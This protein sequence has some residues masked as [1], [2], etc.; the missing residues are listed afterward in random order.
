MEA[1]RSSEMTANYFNQHSRKLDSVTNST[2][3][4]TSSHKINL[5]CS[6]L[7]HP[8]LL[9][10][11]N[12]YSTTLMHNISWDSLMSCCGIRISA[13]KCNTLIQLAYKKKSSF[14]NK[15]RTKACFQ[16][17]WETIAIKLTVVEN[18]PSEVVACEEAW[19]D[20]DEA[21]LAWV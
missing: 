18:V 1:T 15:Y 14:K 3:V 12:I 8:L 2:T 11:M 10:K 17:L 19:V 13:V 6:I 5:L 9:I 7:Q 21:A 20:C 4:R 16:I